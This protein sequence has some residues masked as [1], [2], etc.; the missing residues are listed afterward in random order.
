MCVSSVPSRVDPYE[1]LGVDP[2]A[3]DEE[4]VSAYRERVKEAHPDVGGSA[5]EFRAVQQAYERIQVVDERGPRGTAADET[6]TE[7]DERVSVE[8]LNYA[9]LDDYG[10]ALDDDDL[11]ERA[12]D[13]GLDPIDYGEFVVEPDEFLLEA[14][15]NR[16]FPWPFACRGGACSNCTVALVEGEIPPPTSHV[17]TPE[18]VDRGF[19]LSCITRPTTDVKVV[20]NVKH[21]PTVEELLLP[22]SRFD[23][24]YP[25]K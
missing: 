21:H 2:D 25:T 6:R 14:A 10:W 15:E 4:I 24:A 1:I 19:R 9:A 18:M 17:L 20:Y 11:F 3:D 13:A 8:Y 7:T 16:G 5:R 12:A 23:R 22:A